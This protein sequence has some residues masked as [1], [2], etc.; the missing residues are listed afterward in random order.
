[1]SE[2]HEATSPW[3]TLLALFTIASFIETLFW[4][5]VIDVRSGHW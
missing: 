3:K 2:G 5:Q 1:M 4:G